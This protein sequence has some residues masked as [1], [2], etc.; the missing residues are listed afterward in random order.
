MPVTFLAHQAPVLPVARRWPGAVDGLALVVGSMAPDLAYAVNETRWEVDAHAWPGVVTFGVPVTI[1]ITW[2][3]TRLLAPVVPGHLPDGGGF[4]L[5]D[6]RG[7]A[8]HRLG[9]LRSPL[10]ALVGALSHVALD[11]FTHRRGWFARNFDWYDRPLFDDIVFGRPLTPYRLAQYVG[12]VLL[13]AT[14]AWLLWRWGRTRWLAARAARVPARRSPWSPLLLWA[15]TAGGASAALART[16]IAEG[17]WSENF[18]EDV[19]RLTAGALVGMTVGALAVTWRWR[20]AG[21]VG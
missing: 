19:V 3:I 18:A 2:V 4:H 9:W 21:R 14:T 13:S 6:Y 15:A 1:A 7:L 17:R 12:H 8:T 20:R 11:S 10:G 16:Q 5:H